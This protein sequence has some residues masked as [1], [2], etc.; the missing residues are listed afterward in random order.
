[1]GRQTAVKSDGEQLIKKMT[2]K[3]EKRWGRARGGAGDKTSE[4]H[5]GGMAKVNK[6]NVGRSVQRGKRWE[7]EKQG[8][9]RRN[10]C[11]WACVGREDH[12]GPPR[13]G[14]A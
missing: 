12:N 4:K 11:G 9:A 2:G 14:V 1:M 7:G 5:L 3:K 8:G 10:K 13:T 6:H